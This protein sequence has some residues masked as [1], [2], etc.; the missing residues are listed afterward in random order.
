MPR[1][2]STTLHTAIG[3]EGDL[4]AGGEAGHRLIDGVVDD[5]PNQVMEAPRPGRSDVHA[6]PFAHRFEALEDRDVACVVGHISDSAQSLLHGELGE[7]FRANRG[8]PNAAFRATD[9]MFVI[10]AEPVTDLA[11]PGA[12]E[13]AKTSIFIRFFR[14]SANRI[15]ARS[16]LE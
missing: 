3:Q 10:I 4:G 1:P 2:L 16:G 9:F 6:G 15:R 5:L 14:G 13:G 8:A 12:S 11:I 7:K